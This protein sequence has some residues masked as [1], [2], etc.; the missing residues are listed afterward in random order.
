MAVRIEQRFLLNVRFFLIIFGNFF[1]QVFLIS[2]PSMRKQTIFRNYEIRTERVLILKQYSHT[3]KMRGKLSDDK[4]GLEY[5]FCKQDA[6]VSI[7][8]NCS[9]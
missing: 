6:F 4:N 2:F 3:E 9:Q 5:D 1:L 7:S 8:E